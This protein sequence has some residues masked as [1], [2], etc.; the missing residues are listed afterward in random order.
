MADPLPPDVLDHLALALVPGLGP[1]LTA[2]LLDR[3]G[4]AAAA[5]RV[6]AE[7][8]RD[9]PHIGAKT[10]DALAPALRNVDLDAELRLL[11][12][13]GV[14]PVPLGYKGYPP[15]LAGL[16]NPPPL[17]YFRGEWTAADSTAVGIVGSRSCTAY[18]RRLA[19]G[20][21]RG[22]VRAGFTV[23][24]GLARGIDG[25]AHR[26]ALGAGGRTVAVLAGGLS[27][28]Y[29]PEHADLANEVAG[30]GCLLTETP[31]TVAPQPGMF[32]ARNRII[33]GLSRAV[34]VVEANAR[35]GALITARHALEQGREVFAVP[36]PVD[37]AASAGCLALIRTG[38]RLVRSAD[39][40]L[41]D[42]KGIAAPDYSEPARRAPGV[43]PGSPVT[44]AEEAPAPAEE[45]PPPPPN[46]DPACQQVWDALA[47]RRHA[48]ELAREL[49]LPV[50][51]LATVLM[52]LEVR[53]L[54]RRLPGNFFER[55]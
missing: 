31:M 17:L 14:R 8:L 20:I 21:A 43:S 39:D 41:E 25:A 16:T 33:S 18:G 53:K 37:S 24:S 35:S 12:R 50:A 38:A 4:S 54:V 49:E 44:P 40:I 36:G 34:V 26:A 29:P 32:P 23:V 13:H 10:A 9:I 3:F 5:R 11:E 28:I 19:E 47:S 30:R 6:T 51:K 2:A 55:R 46:L 22:L 15:P 1:R 27:E 52:G 7:Q 42:L 45:P 48:D